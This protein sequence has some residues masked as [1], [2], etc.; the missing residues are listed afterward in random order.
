MSVITIQATEQKY[1]LITYFKNHTT[2]DLKSI[3]VEQRKTPVK[4]RSP[5]QKKYI[6]RIAQYLQ[7]QNRKSPNYKT[8]RQSNPK[9]VPRIEVV[10]PN[11]KKTTVYYTCTITDRFYRPDGSYFERPAILSDSEDEFECCSTDSD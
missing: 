2:D 5:S 10:P 4:T 6:N 9:P 1:P 3:L 11:E 7:R 8:T